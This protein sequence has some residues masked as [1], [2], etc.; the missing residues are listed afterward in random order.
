MG[1]KANEAYN[2]KSYDKFS[3]TSPMFIN[4]YRPGA[5]HYPPFLAGRASEQQEL[6]K[7]LEQ[8][9]ITRNGIITGLRGVGKTVL[10]EAI[11]PVAISNGWLWA[12]SDLSESASVSEERM[13]TR[14]LSDL[15]LAASSVLTEG[16]S[17]NRVGFLPAQDDSAVPLRYE[18]IRAIY[19]D[20]PGLMADK[21]KFVFEKVWEALKNTR[22]M[23]IVFAYDEAQTIS[24]NGKQGQ[25]PVSLLLDVFQG[26]QRMDLPFLLLLTG[27]PTL[28][29]KLVKAHTYAERMFN[30]IDLDRL[31]KAASRDAVTKPLARFPVKFDEDLVTSIVQ[32]SGGY[33]YFLQYIC[34]EVYDIQ[35]ARANAGEPTGQ[36]PIDGIIR[37]LDSDFFQGRWAQLSDRQKDLLVVISKIVGNEEEFSAQAVAQRSGTLLEKG[38]SPSHATQILASLADKGLVYKNRF[39]K[40]SLAVPLLADFIRRQ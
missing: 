16:A 19:D 38:F 34:K 5:G 26:I 32:A 2:D 21:L 4:P 10:L 7:L 15:T 11:R 3:M 23:G 18:T 25:F 40:Y 31:S 36:V 37:K 1:Q 12:A 17:M 8:E 28:F 24:N 33:P 39:G 27:L 6:L 35:A 30:I 13:A 9:V 29:P 22:V 14:I 20:R